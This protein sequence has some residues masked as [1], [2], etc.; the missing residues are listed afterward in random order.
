M[1]YKKHA[2]LGK[3][4]IS[5]WPRITVD[6]QEQC[7]E[8]KKEKLREVDKE[9]SKL[10]L[11]FDENAFLDADRHFAYR[12]AVGQ[13]LW[14]SLERPDLQYSI[15]K[16]SQTA[17]KPTEADW[18]ALRRV[19]RYMVGVAETQLRYVAPS[20]GTP[21]AEVVTT[22]VDSDWAGCRITRRSTSGGVIKVAGCLVLSWS[23]VQN[24]VACSSGEAEFYAICMGAAES[25]FVHVV[26][27]DLGI[28][29]SEIPL[30][31][32]PTR[33]PRKPWSSVPVFLRG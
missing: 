13:L 31:S 29:S 2:I 25:L 21:G 30:C 15:K 20:S 19:A 1:L 28:S 5:K 16:L 10:S 17:S 7:Q 14:L 18:C 12:R 4:Q 3:K 23:R 33:V 9:L 8:H 26:A 27:S 22:W 24:T 6:E 11:K 32:S